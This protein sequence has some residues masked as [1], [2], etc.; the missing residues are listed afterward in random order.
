MRKWFILLAL[1]LLAGCSSQ[2]AMAGD[3][4]A[5]EIIKQYPELKDHK[6][7]VTSVKR[8][9]DGDTF[10]TEEGDKVRLIGVNTPET[11][12]PNSPVET[13]G[14]EASDFTKKQ[15]SGKT[16][17]MFSDAGDKDKYSRLL[18]YVFI[19]GEQKMFNEVLISEGYANTMT[20]PPN[21]LYADKF[22]KLEKTARDNNKGLWGIDSGSKKSKK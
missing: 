20:I 5:K 11:V 8:V 2:S 7:T 6:F 21:V 22:V 18:R 10:Q 16:V 19:Q 1:M 9:V 3:S 14:K 13:Y 15:L 12:K 4:Y 17:Y